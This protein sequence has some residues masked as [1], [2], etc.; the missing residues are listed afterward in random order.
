MNAA[1]VFSNRTFLYR[2]IH[3]FYHHANEKQLAYMKPRLPYLPTYEKRLT[4][5]KDV[6]L[7]NIVAKDV[8]FVSRILGQKELPVENVSL[9][10]ITT[11]MVQEK[12]THPRESER[13]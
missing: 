4:P 2:S 7:S 3:V 8:K 1:L 5:I 9:K 12:K 11:G 6:F 10:K 13:F